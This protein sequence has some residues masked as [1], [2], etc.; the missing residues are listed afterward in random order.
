MGLWTDEAA[1]M[2]DLLLFILPSFCHLN[3]YINKIALS[4][5]GNDDAGLNQ[6]QKNIKSLLECELS[7]KW[8]PGHMVAPQTNK[9][10]PLVGLFSCCDIFTSSFVFSPPVSQPKSDTN[11]S[12]Q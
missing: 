11:I 4:K 5:E 6:V 1:P 10:N 3:S 7:W 8:K 9:L 12:S 2:F